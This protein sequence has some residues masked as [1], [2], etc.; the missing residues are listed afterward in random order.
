M[1]LKLFRDLQKMTFIMFNKKVFHEREIC[2]FLAVLLFSS[3][4]DRHRRKST[5]SL[6]LMCQGQLW[7]KT[8]PSPWLQPECS[9]NC[10]LPY[11]FAVAPRS[12]PTGK[13]TRFL[14]LAAKDWYY[15]GTSVQ[16]IIE[17]PRVSIQV[18]GQVS[19]ILKMYYISFESLWIS[20]HI[21]LFHPFPSPSTSVLHPCNQPPKKKIK[22][23]IIKKNKQKPKNSIFLWKLQCV[24]VCYTVYPFAQTALLA[25]VHWQWV[26]S[27]LV[28]GL[29]LLLTH[30]Y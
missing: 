12:Y 21:P 14:G 18:V 25:N 7:V 10:E 6:F 2:Y 3:K 15:P 22:N 9:P 24:L 5:W 16:M 27:G 26:I 29:W 17:K 13:S 4:E 28:W 20:H 30:E 8:C 19:V 23:I 11:H 1:A